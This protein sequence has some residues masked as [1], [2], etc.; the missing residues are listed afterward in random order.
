MA[1]TYVSNIARYEG[2]PRVLRTGPSSMSA[3]DRLARFLG[4]FS[5]G[6][7]LMEIVAPGRLTRA[8]GME[9]SENTVR[10]YGLREI[11][12]GIMSLSVDKEL[13]LWSR[14]AGDGLDLATLLPATD[15]DNPKRDNVG[16]A[17]ALVAGITLLDLLAAQGVRARHREGDGMRRDYRDRSGFPQGVQA[18]RGAARTS[19]QPTQM[20]DVKVH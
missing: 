13:G 9:G 11:G 12:A 3:V 5:I 4:W 6:L 16:L 20:E 7:G 10:A 18:A 19:K 1:M 15:A 14:V 8:L 17:V 2:D